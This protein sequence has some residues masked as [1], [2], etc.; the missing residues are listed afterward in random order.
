MSRTVET[1]IEIRLFHVAIRR[2]TS[3]P[4]KEVST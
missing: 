2:A 3:I 4:T 1:V